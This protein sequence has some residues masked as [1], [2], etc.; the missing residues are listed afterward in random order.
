M[1]VPPMKNGSRG[2]YGFHGRG[3]PCHV[4]ALP[5]SPTW[6]ATV[7]ELATLCG[8]MRRPAAGAGAPVFDR[9]GACRR[10]ALRHAGVSLGILL[11]TSLPAPAADNTMP[12]ID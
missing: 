5:G 2:W 11:G 9:R 12:M 3:R 4:E 6:L 10:L 8:M 1:G 7:A